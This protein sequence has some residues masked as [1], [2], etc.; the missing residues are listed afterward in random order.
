MGFIGNQSQ[1]DTLAC[2]F[3]DCNTYDEHGMGTPF[4]TQSSS[5]GI[6]QY[7]ERARKSLMIPL[8]VGFPN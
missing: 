1:M 7:A 6:S 2:Q 8:W 3:R 5:A 4:Q